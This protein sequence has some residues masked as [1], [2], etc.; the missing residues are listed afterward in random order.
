M[1]DE[2]AHVWGWFMQLDEAR[3][4]NGFGPNPISYSEIAWWAMLTGTAP[5]SFEVS[6]I[7]AIDALCLAA[8]AEAKK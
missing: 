4:N 6:L 3:G 1:P 7:R 5:T 2:L 8:F